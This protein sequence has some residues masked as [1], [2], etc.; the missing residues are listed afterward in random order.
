MD[1]HDQNRLTKKFLAELQQKDEGICEVTIL[2]AMLALVDGQFGNGVAELIANSIRSAMGK[3]DGPQKECLGCLQP[4]TFHR[5]IHGV[6]LGRIEDMR[7]GFV[8]GLCGSCFGR[9]DVQRMV[10]D[11]ICR[12]YGFQVLGIVSN[13]VGHA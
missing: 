12:D 13:D 8:A 2:P 3:P 4:W 9:D 10:L 5:G 6:V 7:H 11:G 1:D